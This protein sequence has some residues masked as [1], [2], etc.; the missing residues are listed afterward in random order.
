MEWKDKCCGLEQAEIYVLG[1]KTERLDGGDKLELYSK[2][3]TKIL[4]QVKSTKDQNL[5]L[6]RKNG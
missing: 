1:T 2:M 6:V 5:I 3:L 4:S